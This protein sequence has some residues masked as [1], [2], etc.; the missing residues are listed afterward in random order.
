M[1]QG[2]EAMENMVVAVVV[3]LPLTMVAVHYSAL[4]VVD[5]VAVIMLLALL[6]G[7]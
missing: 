2:L 4:L 3:L 7:T 1:L 5:R 6:V